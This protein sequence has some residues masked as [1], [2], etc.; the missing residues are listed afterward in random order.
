MDAPQLSGKA[1]HSYPHTRAVSLVSFARPGALKSI[2]HIIQRG[3][4]ALYPLCCVG[5]G[6][7]QN[8]QAGAVRRADLLT[9]QDK[10]S[11]GAMKHG[12]R[13]IRG[14]RAFSPV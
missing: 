12:I 8:P 4:I 7:L 14:I 6:R 11:R 10:L 2:E 13:S 1:A 9:Q 3:R 5:A